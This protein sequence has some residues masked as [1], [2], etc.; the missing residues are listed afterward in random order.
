[1]AL[2]VHAARR[3]GLRRAGA[4]G[5]RRRDLAG[6]AAQAAGAGQPQRLL[7]RARSHRR[8]VPVR[9]AVREERDVGD[10]VSTPKGRPIMVPNMEPSLEGK[11]VCPSLDGASNWYSTSFNPVDRPVLRADQRQVRHL[12]AGR[13]WS[14]RRARASWAVRSG[15]R[16]TS[17][18]SASC[19]RSTSRPAKPSWELPQTGAVNSWG[20]VLSTAGG[21]VIFGEDSGALMAA[22]AADRQAA[23]ELPDESALEGVADDLSVRQQAVRRGRRRVEHHRVWVAGLII[24][25]GTSRSSLALNTDQTANDNRCR[26]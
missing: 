23:V 9:H 25:S 21:V 20:G 22:D 16:R 2:P 12:H 14:G 24:S 10:A 3:L 7:L 6:A 1:M 5:A 15:R 18:R 17:R 13:R 19:A 11:R 26:S 8:H 4:A